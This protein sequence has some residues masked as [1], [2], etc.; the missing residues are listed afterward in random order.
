M[1]SL[2]PCL[3]KG[4]DYSPSYTPTTPSYRPTTPSYRPTSPP[5]G[6][7]AEIV[8]VIRRDLFK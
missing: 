1:K 7:G 8:F 6:K 5:T 4:P 3:K 2:L